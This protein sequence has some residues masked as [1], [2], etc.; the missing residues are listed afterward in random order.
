MSVTYELVVALTHDQGK[1]VIGGHSSHPT[2]EGARVALEEY[3]TS[4]AVKVAGYRITRV[5]SKEVES[6]D[7]DQLGVVLSRKKFF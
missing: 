3:R 1:N 5:E 7:T 4:T 6:E 2:L